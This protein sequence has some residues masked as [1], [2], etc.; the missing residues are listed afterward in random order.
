MRRPIAGRCRSTRT[1][2][3]EVREEVRVG[4]ARRA[5]ERAQVASCLRHSLAAMGR[6]RQ[7]RRLGEI[8]GAAVAR[9]CEIAPDFV[10]VIADRTCHGFPLVRFWGSG[11]LHVPMYLN[12]GKTTPSLDTHELMFTVVV[13]FRR[14]SLGA[15]G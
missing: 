13:R 15:T 7:A 9:A 1:T 5:F 12:T 3:A 14:A 8:K 2:F 11:A 6:H 10:T 4:N